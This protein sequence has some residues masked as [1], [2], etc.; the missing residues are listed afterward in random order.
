M[1]EPIAT[2]VIVVAYRSGRHLPAC[3]EALFVHHA[4][5][6]AESTT[7]LVWAGYDEAQRCE[8]LS[9]AVLAARRTAFEAVGGFDERFFMYCEDTDLCVRLRDRGLGVWY[10]P[11]ATA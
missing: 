3:A 8:W 6:H 1:R 9:G 10:E 11:S 2:D 7:E 5:R 4:L